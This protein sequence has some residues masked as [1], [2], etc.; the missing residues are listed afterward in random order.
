MG[1]IYVWEDL[2]KTPAM[3]AQIQSRRSC[4][5]DML[6]AVSLSF[7]STRQELT[8]NPSKF[9]YD[10]EASAIK[11]ANGFKSCQKQVSSISRLQH[12][13]HALGPT[14]QPGLVLLN[15]RH[16]FALAKEKVAGEFLD[17]A[18]SRFVSKHDGA[19][20]NYVPLV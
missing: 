14:Y 16:V 6:P 17:Q 1:S 3:S 7:R 8:P 4:K 11:S 2:W 13:C 12:I 5:L 10:D 15:E 9:V 18:A 20:D 19:E